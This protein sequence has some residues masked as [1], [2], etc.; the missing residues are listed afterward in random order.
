[1]AAD[2]PRGR[3]AK[4][5][6]R[7]RS[8]VSPSFV[9]RPAAR[10]SLGGASSPMRVRMISR[11][12]C[13][14]NPGDDGSKSLRARRRSGLAAAFHEPVGVHRHERTRR[15][16]L[17][18]DDERRSSSPAP[19]SGSGVGREQD[20]SSPGPRPGRGRGARPSRCAPCRTARGSP[21]PQGWRR[22]RARSAA[23]SDRRARAPFRA[24]CRGA[25]TR[26]VP[27]GCAPSR[28]PRR[29]RGPDV[30]DHDPVLARRELEQV[31]P[32]SSHRA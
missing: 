17:N 1:M 9:A 4:P 20:R 29:V 24:G 14:L 19:R 25:C 27:I 15:E 23:S 22:C 8:A 6:R 16:G 32:V 10:M 7:G 28:P 30:A 21:P 31:V 5:V 12:T 18:S 2:Y 13:W 3:A 26:A 11:A